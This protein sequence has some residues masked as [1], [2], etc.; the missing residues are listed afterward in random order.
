MESIPGVEA[1]DR[2]HG[3]LPLAGGLGLPFTI[4]GR[5]LT[6]GP[7]H[8]GGDWSYVGYRY[9]D[10]FHIPIVR[11]RAF[12]IR[13]DGAA[14]PVAIIN[15]A[16]ARSSGRRRIRWARGSASGKFPSRCSIEPPREIV[17]V[18]G[19]VHDDGLNVDPQPKMFVPIGQVKDAVMAMNNR[20]MPL[21]WAVRTVGDPYRSSA[22]IQRVLQTSADLPAADVQS[23][24]RVVV[25]STSREPVQ[26]PAAWGV[27]IHRNPAGVH[28]TLRPDVVCRG[29]ADA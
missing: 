19:D 1:A 7:F 23:M 2:N 21:S 20:F 3:S 15:E 18:A 13:D 27:R 16:M 9:F 12:S 11:G 17:G 29:A 22:V 6:D 14:A 24:D 26:Y 25:R 4:E 10:V 5:A 28:R 8:G